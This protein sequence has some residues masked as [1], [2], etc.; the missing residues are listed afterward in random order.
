M[1]EEGK[2]ESPSFFLWKPIPM[3]YRRRPLFPGNQKKQFENW[4]EE[5]VDK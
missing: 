1:K 5:E 3:I 4:M 2:G